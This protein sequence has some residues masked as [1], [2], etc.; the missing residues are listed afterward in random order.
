MLTVLGQ[1]SR[2]ALRRGLFRHLKVGVVETVREGRN[3][4]PNLLC[5]PV[6]VPFYER[7]VTVSVDKILGRDQ[8]L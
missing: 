5:R 2:S 7:F 1:R 3:G 4:P 6:V 8:L